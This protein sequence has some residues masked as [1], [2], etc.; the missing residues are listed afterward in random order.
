MEKKQVSKRHSSSDT[1][2][3]SRPS[4]SVRVLIVDDNEPWRR[5]IY[6]ELGS[7]QQLQ[8]VGE[9]LD[10]LEAVRKA[11][12][13]K[14]EIILLDIGLPKLNGLEAANRIA[15]RV[16]DSKIVFLT[17]QDDPDVVKQALS[18]GATGYV[19]KADAKTE[20]LAAIASVLHGRRFVSRRLSIES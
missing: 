4:P 14:P 3:A 8:I 9:A 7:Q 5:W 17:T 10:G 18:N 12:E 16:P 19:L 20:L 6:T 15:Q 13:F 2:A 1:D 11:D